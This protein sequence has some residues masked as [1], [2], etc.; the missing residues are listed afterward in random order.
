MIALLNSLL[1]GLIVLL[2]AFYPLYLFFSKKGYTTPLPAP[3]TQPPALSIIIPCFNEENNIEHKIYDLLTACQHHY[4]FEIILLSDGSTDGTD[5]IL[6][7]WADHP[8]FQILLSE[9]RRGKPYQINR[10]VAHAKYEWLLLSDARQRLDAFSVSNLVRHLH[11]PDVS[12]VSSRLVNGGKDSAIRRWVNFFKQKESETGSTVGAYGAFYTVRRADFEPIP[13]DLILD[14]LFVPVMLIAKGK[15]VSFEPESVI[16]DIDIERFYVELRIAR[17]ITG[18]V[19]FWRQ[20][21]S[22]IAR[23]PLRYQLY[24]FFQKYL[25][26]VLPMLLVA[27]YLLNL[28]LLDHP[29]FRVLFGL[30]TA[31]IVFSG[32]AMLF[33]GGRDIR[34]LY[35]LLFRYFF[36]FA[37][38][39]DSRDVKWKKATK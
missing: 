6:K 9:E 5:T 1:C 19:Q 31:F 14:D 27:N 28:F 8:N 11:Q 33:R 25:K 7:K 32:V 17:M 36:S 2:V 24:L 26:L 22:L 16:Y 13:E 20:H 18:L 37:H 34:L 4:T 30:E 15:R 10:G 39:R 38:A 3:N 23:M 29:F 21:S 12:A 35:T